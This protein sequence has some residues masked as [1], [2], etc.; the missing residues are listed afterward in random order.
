MF[1]L[2]Q[3]LLLQGWATI[4]VFFWAVPTTKFLRMWFRKLRLDILLRHAEEVERCTFR[5]LRAERDRALSNNPTPS[6]QIKIHTDYS[7]KHTEARKAR[8]S[9]ELKY[10][11]KRENIVSFYWFA[12]AWELNIVAPAIPRDKDG[13]FVGYDNDDLRILRAEVRKERLSSFGY[14]AKILTLTFALVGIVGKFLI[15]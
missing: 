1:G 13:N 15:S 6:E 2:M 14:W 7:N 4:Q 5:R 10:Y 12:A 3:S 11:I 9:A 8:H